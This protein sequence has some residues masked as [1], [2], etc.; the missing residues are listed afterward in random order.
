M[1]WFAFLWP[2]FTAWAVAEEAPRATPVPTPDVGVPVEAPDAGVVGA[3]RSMSRSLQFSVRGSDGLIRGSVAMLADET[4]D[5]LLRLTEEK[6]EWKVPIG[7]VLYGKSGDPMPP[8]SVEMQLF[9]N[10]SSYDLRVNVHLSRGI[11]Q[12]RFQRAIT[13]ALIYERALR[14]RPPGESET[15]LIVPPWLVEGLREATA[16]RLKTSDRKL[17]EALFKHGGLYKLEDLFAVDDRAHE[18]MDAAMRA[19]FRV[20]S[21]ALVMALLEQPQGKEGFRTF[22]NEIAVYDGEMPV[23]L[24]RNFPE[25]NLSETSMAKWWALQ[26]ANKGTAPLTDILS[27]SETEAALNDLLKIQIRAEDGTPENRPVAEWEK[28][29]EMKPPEKVEAV[30]QAQDELVRLS[31]RCFPSYRPLLAEYQAV[32][33]SMTQGKTEKVAGQLQSLEES[34]NL[35]REKAARARDF[36]DWF[37]ITRARETSGTFDDFLQFKEATKSR[38]IQRDDDISRYLDRMDQIFS[39]GETT[40]N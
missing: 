40:P 10:E 18:K 21:G 39:R 33:A 37:E 19:A 23:L 28:L 12:D 31:Y 30:R 29:H 8:R 11:E 35:M 9:F 5:E 24:R 22:L 34:R 38:V 20:S 7:I 14:T 3:D 4:K 13:A 32:L 16:W 2:F 36:M 27:V 25:L 15:P 1:K 17:Y 6:D 26:L